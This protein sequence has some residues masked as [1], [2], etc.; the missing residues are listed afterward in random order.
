[1]IWSNVAIDY[2]AGLDIFDPVT[3]IIYTNQEAILQD[4]IIKSR[5]IMNPRKIGCFVMDLNDLDK[6]RN[7]KLYK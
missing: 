5:L 2:D 7:N 1:M 3:N 6:I 4:D